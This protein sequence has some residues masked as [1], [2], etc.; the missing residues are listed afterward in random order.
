MRFKSVYADVYARIYS[1]LLQQ[2][3][4]QFYELL[5]RGFPYIY[6]YIIYISVYV[7]MRDV[8][9]KS[10]GHSGKSIV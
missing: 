3:E 6:I 5:A 7:Y 9:C 8:P 1:C 4:S 2:I 10:G